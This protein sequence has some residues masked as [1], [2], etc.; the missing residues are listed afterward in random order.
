MYAN[1]FIRNIK[2]YIIII[3]Q[4]KVQCVFI[5]KRFSLKKKKVIYLNYVNFN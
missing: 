1:V 2:T 3:I 4:L 5:N